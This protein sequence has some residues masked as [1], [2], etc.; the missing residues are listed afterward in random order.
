MTVIF[1]VVAP[2]GTL[3]LIEV[4]VAEITAGAPA[5][6][7]LKRTSVTRVRLVPLMVI[8]DPTAPLGVNEDMIGG[9]ITVKL[10]TLN[11]VP[12][13]VVTLI[14]PIVGAVDGITATIALSLEE[15]IVANTE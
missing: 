4:E 5:L 14:L 11:V 3:T 7:P 15:D 10:S 6:V 9:L 2:I 12:P 1:P 8:G 13:V